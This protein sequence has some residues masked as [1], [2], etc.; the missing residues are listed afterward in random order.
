MAWTLV[1]GAAKRLGASICLE[2]ARAGHN[3]VIHYRQSQDEAEALAVTLRAF[4]VKA[5]T[6]RGD[7]STAESLQEFLREY[8][9][10]F[11]ATR[12][13]VNNVGNYLIE[14]PSETAPIK[15]HELFETNFF[16]PV[17]L[18]NAL[19]SS[20]K[21]E[22]GAVVNIG[23]A[24]ISKLKVDVNAAA[25]TMSKI[26]LLAYTKSLAKE[27]A[28][29]LVRVNMVSPGYI[30]NAVDLPDDL[31]VL[32]MKRAATPEEVARVVRFLLEP[33][34]AYITGQNIEVAGGVGL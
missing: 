27:V 32:P 23:V 19:L 17:A 15:W 26:A 14:P 16:A 33:A 30:D 28:K 31:S 6:I 10:Q 4:G 1:T 24:G 8:Q 20:L 7:F 11:L 9:R 21:Q 18:T 12:F 25:Y 2:L 22:R 3:L 29:D 5:E 13:V 34:S